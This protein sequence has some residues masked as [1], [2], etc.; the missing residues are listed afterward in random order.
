VDIKNILYGF[1]LNLEILKISIM[2]VLKF[3][4]V[5]SI[6]LLS[7]CAK[8]PCLDVTCLNDS[9]CDDG[10]CLCAD[11]YEGTDC[12]TE[13]R[14][15]YYGTYV[16]AFNVYDADGVLIQVNQDSLQVAEG[17]SINSLDAN[18]MP[19]VLTTSG[20]SSFNIPIT[21]MDG[22]VYQGNGSFNETSLTVNGTFVIQAD[23]MAF[24]FSGTK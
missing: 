10:T 2:K 21:L 7:S 3:F 14:V 8:D 24:T 9:Q 23:T 11:W 22:G 16:G 4:V 20:S 12:G 19:F 13:E 5:S 1:F 15:K 17:G 6:L 18:G